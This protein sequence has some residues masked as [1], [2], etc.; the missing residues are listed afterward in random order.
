[1]FVKRIIK[2]W[3]MVV[4]TWFCLGNH[5]AGFYTFYL[6]EAILILTFFFA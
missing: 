6:L 1:M 5:L 4:F 3:V 2:Q